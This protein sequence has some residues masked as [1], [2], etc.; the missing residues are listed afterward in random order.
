VLSQ[1][2]IIKNGRTLCKVLTGRTS[3]T[4]VASINKVLLRFPDTYQLVVGRI[5]KKT[6]FENA[7]VTFEIRD[8]SGNSA[9]SA[10][11]NKRT[12]S[13]PF[14]M[15]QVV[16]AILYLDGRAETLYRARTA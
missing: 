10:T 1:E 12:L 5:F 14:S 2:P 9:G 7:G 13:F 8:A 3:A 4:P 16:D 6:T 15:Q 11:Q